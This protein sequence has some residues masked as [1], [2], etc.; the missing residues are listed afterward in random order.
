MVFEV[1]LSG[2]V[3]YVVRNRVVFLIFKFY[4][5]EVFNVYLIVVFIEV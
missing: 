3:W 4:N 1:Y 5:R 2:D